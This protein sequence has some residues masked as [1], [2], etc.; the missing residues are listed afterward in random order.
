MATARYRG[1][2]A[3]TLENDHLRL[4]VLESGGH[5]AEVH[6]KPTGVNPLWTPPWPSI[7]ST[8]Y[9]RDRHAIYGSGVD[10]SLLAGIMGHSLCLDIF[11]GPSADEAEAG[12]PVHGEVSTLRFELQQVD[13][14]IV[15]DAQLPL[16]R[17]QF[18]RRIHLSRDV[19]G[20]V[21]ITESVENLSGL[22]HPVGWT[23]HVTLGP[24]FLERGRTQFRASAGRST[25]F[26]QA[27]GSADYLEAGG[28]FQWPMA[29]R[30][31]GGTVDMRV[32]G[33]A[34]RSS[35]YTA[36]LMEPAGEHAFFLAFS[37]AS[38]L[39]F[40]Y[41]WRRAD[42]PWLGIWEENGSRDQP[43]WNGQTLARGME[44]GVSPFPET[45]REMIE[46]RRLFDVPTFRWIPAARRIDVEYWIVAL[47]ADTIPEALRWPSA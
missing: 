43:P 31:G 26:P 18:E 29:P 21:R 8:S 27:F 42:F 9:D 14:D 36:H 13:G 7:D 47:Q 12:L 37:P 23:Q 46:R 35:A 28:E 40:G 16:A 32:L 15:M 3:A 44:F 34:P 39:A 24:P 22:D 6:H 11:G 10:A 19:P 38:R 20:A 33:E 1:R 5:I 17:L 41:V 30:A 45:R 25:V 2:R 4:T